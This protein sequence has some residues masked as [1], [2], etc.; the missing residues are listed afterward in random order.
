MKAPKMRLLFYFLIGLLLGGACTYARSADYAVATLAS[1][2]FDRNAR[3]NERNFGLGLE[4]SFGDTSI[5]VGWWDN[6]L[7]KTT[8]YGIFGYA[9]WHVGP[10]KFGA[11]IGGVT[12]YNCGTHI[13]PAGALLMQNDWFNLAATPMAIALQVKW[14]FAE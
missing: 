4:H 1:Y 14:K 6:S 12:G 5:S 7:G 11:A 2:H 3:Y 13:C 8:L 10:V 9:P